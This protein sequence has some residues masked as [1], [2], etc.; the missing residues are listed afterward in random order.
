MN[1]DN[2]KLEYV[3]I[4]P[5]KLAELSN[6][7]FGTR[8]AN[9]GMIT[10]SWNSNAISL[11]DNDVLFSVVVKAQADVMISK[12]LSISSALTKAEAYTQDEEVL[13]VGLQFTENG[14]VVATEGFEMYQNKPNPFSESTTVGF[15]LPEAS[16][17]SLTIYDMSG[18]IVK[19]YDNSF[20]KG[21]NA[22]EVK[23]VDLGSTGVFYYRIDTPTHSGTKKMVIVK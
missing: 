22:F 2:E 4:L 20:S 15:N 8:F 16:N 1:L 14:K 23:T 11:A 21:Y 19:S 17:V 9:E 18:R 10:T 6:D 3:N 5:G 7:N 13:N 12:A